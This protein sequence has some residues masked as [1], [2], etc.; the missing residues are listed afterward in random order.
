MKDDDELPGRVD[1]CLLVH[2][3]RIDDVR[4][5]LAADSRLLTQHR[6]VRLLVSKCCYMA[7]VMT[8]PL[9]VLVIA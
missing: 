4:A 7:R 5:A 1:L 6:W 8:M 9:R 3:R 2:Q